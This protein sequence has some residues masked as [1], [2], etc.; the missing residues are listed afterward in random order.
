MA[1]IYYSLYD[2]MLH[3]KG[4]L[5]AFVKVK[6]KTRGTRYRRVDR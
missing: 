6:S 2:R 3:E 4:L 1:K 5:Q